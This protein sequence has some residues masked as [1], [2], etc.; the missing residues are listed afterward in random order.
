VSSRVGRREGVGSSSET[1]A[2]RRFN[3]RTSSKRAWGSSREAEADTAP[4]AP[5]QPRPLEEEA[6]EGADEGGDH[7]RKERKHQLEGCALGLAEEECD[8]EEVEDE[9]VR[10]HLQIAIAIA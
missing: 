8:R 9:R 4:S 1:D 5:S 7:R 3:L 10:E 2:R 6:G